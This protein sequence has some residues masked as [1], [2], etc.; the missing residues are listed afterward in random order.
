MEQYKPY[1]SYKP[2]GTEWL[3][4]IPCH[5]QLHKL[6]HL[7]HIQFSS[8]DK[9][10]IE[11]ESPVQLCNYTD[12]YKNE[13]ITDSVDFMRATGSRLEIEKS[14]ITK[15]D[16]LVTKDSESWT[17][18]VIPAY[19]MHDFKN[20]VLCGYHLAL[21]RPNNINGRYLF[22]ALQSKI[23]NYQFQIEAYGITRYGIGKS[24]LGN[25]LIHAPLLSEQQSIADFLDYETARIDNLIAKYQ[26]LI[27]LL[28]EKR[29]ALITHAVTRGL[30]PDVPLKDSGVEWLGKIPRNWQLNRGKYIAWLN[31]GGSLAEDT[32]ENGNVPVY[33][34]NGVIGEHNKPNTLSPCIIIG[35][36]GSYGK[37]NYSEGECYAIDTTYY[38]DNSKCKSNLRWLFCLFG[39]L[40]LDESSRDSAVPGLDREV[41]HNKLLPL[42]TLEEQQSIADFLDCETAKIDNL[43]SKIESMIKKMQEYRSAFITAAVT[44]KIDVRGNS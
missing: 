8:V 16:V 44:G 20:K 37:I 6:K 14:Y 21:I 3:G 1:S 5:W 29:A 12:V 43:V 10:S 25:G 11:G 35:R 15:G 17:D 27:E 34:S 41:V 30:D 32:R 31:Y 9:I 7:S 28:Q 23:I 26:R 4:E 2:S 38:I 24:S 40:K 42:P 33:G 36:K 39:I 22:R 18:I 13:F 19:V